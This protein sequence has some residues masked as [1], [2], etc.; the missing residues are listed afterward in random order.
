MCCGAEA[1]PPVCL[2]PKPGSEQTLAVLDLGPQTG[3]YL[4]ECWGILAWKFG[5]SR[6]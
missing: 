1:G 2:F 6:P 3:L 5:T 4:T